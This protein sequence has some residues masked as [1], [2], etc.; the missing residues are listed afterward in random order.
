[1]NPPASACA[2]PLSLFDSPATVPAR[3]PNPL[4]LCLLT[5]NVQHA[6]PQ[7]ARRQAAWLAAS[8]ADVLVLTEVADSDGGRALV[9]ALQEWGFTTHAPARTARDYGVLLAARGVTLEPVDAVTTGHLPH[10]CLAA[11]MHAREMS[12]GV[13]GL[14]VPSR[15]GKQGRNVAK[16]AFQ[17]A[18]VAVLP[19][20]AQ[21]LPAADDPL[22]VAGDLNVLEPGHRPHHAVFGGWEYDFYR[23][24][25]D[26]ALDDVFRHLNPDAAGHSWYGRSGAGYRFD[27]MFCSRQHLPRV[28]GV[29]YLHEPRL[30]GLSDHAAMA[31]TVAAKP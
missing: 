28:T 18:V 25:A 8:G 27:H 19:T 4:G 16:R 12:L 9:C 14:Y 30:A 21:A 1:M 13:V 22:I 29:G 5:W 24:F 31:A 2:P 17:H 6:G 26:A 10:R 3:T 15:G 7:R 20:L 11:R 23:A